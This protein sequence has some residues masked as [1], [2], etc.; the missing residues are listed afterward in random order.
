M[1]FVTVGTQLAFDRLVDGVAA[2]QAR[3]PDIETFGQIGPSKTRPPFPHID[4]LRGGAFE[5]RLRAA[6]LV[7]S[8]AGIGII[9]SCWSMKKPLIIMPREHRL[10]EHRSDH[11]LATVQHLAKLIT[12]HPAYTTDE[13]HA[14]LSEPWEALVPARAQDADAERISDFVNGLLSGA[15]A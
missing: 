4:Y 7:V 11:Q 3:H 15:K 9:L 5:S 12:L 8:H 2:W 10:G 14:L 13:L 6:D 1:I